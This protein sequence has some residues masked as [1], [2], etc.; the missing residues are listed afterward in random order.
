MI[1]RELL[2]V[3][4]CWINIYLISMFIPAGRKGRGKGRSLKCI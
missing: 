1:E 3:L 4:I 2:Y